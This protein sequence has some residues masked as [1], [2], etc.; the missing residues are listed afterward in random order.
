MDRGTEGE[1]AVGDNCAHFGDGEVGAVGISDAGGHETAH[2]PHAGVPVD[3]SGVAFAVA[4]VIFEIDCAMRYRFDEIGG[5]LKDACGHGAAERDAEGR[6]EEADDAHPGVF[7]HD[8]RICRILVGLVGNVRHDTLHI[9]R[10]GLV[11]DAGVHGE[12]RRRGPGKNR[13]VGCNNDA[14]GENHA[15]L[16]DRDAFGIFGAFDTAD[17]YHGVLHAGAC[18]VLPYA[19]HVF[20]DGVLGVGEA[21]CLVVK[22]QNRLLRMRIVILG[23]HEPGFSGAVVPFL[24]VHEARDS[25]PEILRKRFPVSGRGVE[26]EAGRNRD[27]PGPGKGA[28]AHLLDNHKGCT[29]ACDC[30]KW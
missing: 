28:G 17:G 10:R 4:A 30:N 18:D 19:Q 22:K 5:V 25:R 27:F 29:G 21:N 8:V 23:I 16:F 26:I 14:S 20:G 1:A 7:A 9:W 24:G 12:L 13:G 2:V 3:E 15:L 11:H 6:V